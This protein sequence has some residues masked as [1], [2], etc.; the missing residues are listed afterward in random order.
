MP[1]IVVENEDDVTTGRGQALGARLEQRLIQLWELY[2]L[3]RE[4][5]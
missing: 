2:A 3:K 4:A 5:V 1:Y